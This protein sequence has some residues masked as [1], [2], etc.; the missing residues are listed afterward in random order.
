MA[1]NP[2]EAAEGPEGPVNPSPSTGD[3]SGGGSSDGGGYAPD[4]ELPLAGYATLAAVFTSGAGLFALWARR[5]GRVLPSDVPPWDLFL[6]GTAAYKTSRL[7]AKDKIT[8]FVRAPFTRRQ[9]VISASEVTDAP[10]GHG[11]R[12]AAGELLACPFCLGAWVA[13]GLVCGYATVPRATRLI[14][15]GLTAATVSDWLQYAWSF[16]QQ[17]V[18]N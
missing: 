11:L 16:T 5:S 18:D 1:F 4:E 12:L 15:A 17:Q 8:S 9:E 6:L 13:G 7:V 14:A 3:A 10:R 2:L